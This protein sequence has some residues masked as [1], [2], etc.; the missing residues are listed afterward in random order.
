MEKQIELSEWQRNQMEGITKKRIEFQ[1]KEDL[2]VK[3]IIDCN[4]IDIK[5]VQSVNFNNN[6]LFVVLKELT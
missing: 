6:K 4:G 3:T 5:T 2:L 1:E